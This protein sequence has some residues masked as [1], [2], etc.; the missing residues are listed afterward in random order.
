M[1]AAVAWPNSKLYLF[2]GSTYSRYDVPSGAFEADGQ[3]I[4]QFWSGLW[5]DGIDAA[6]YWGFGKAFF[7]RGDE[8]ARYDEDSDSVEYVRKINASWPGLWEFGIDAAINWTNGKIYLFR[9][10]E[11]VRWDIAHDR[12]DEGYPRPIAGNWQGIWE[13]GVDAAVYPGG[14]EVYFFKGDVYRVFNV[15][16]DRS[17]GT[18]LS[19]SSFAPAPLPAGLM[20]AARDLT[21]AEAAGIAIWQSNRGDYAFKDSWTSLR[22]DADGAIVS[23]DPKK[24]VAVSPSTIGKVEYRNIANPLSGLV[25]NLDL[26][27]LIALERLGRWLNGDKADVDAVVH[28]GI[29]HGKGPANDCH[30]EGRALDLAG[31]AG[32]MGGAEFSISVLDDWGSQ[33]ETDKGTY[34]LDPSTSPVAFDLFK[35]AYAFGTYECECKPSNAWPPTEIGEG[36]MVICPDYWG[37]DAT[38]REKY[39]SDHNNHIHMQIGPTR[40]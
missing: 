37:E 39:R 21:P 16:A 13:D 20:T 25:D 11:Y 10:P 9:G 32:G 36:G 12:M 29:G 4:E 8:Y 5:P 6:V 18:D 15:G 7:F 17:D 23:L 14:D 30:N 3:S 24:R 40:S 22:R 19:I 35:R 34:R 33:P 2:S 26:R 28:L 38:N 1:D 27:M 31:I